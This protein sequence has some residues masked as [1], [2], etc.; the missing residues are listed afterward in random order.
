M[1]QLSFLHNEFAHTGLQMLNHLKGVRKAYV[2][3]YEEKEREQSILMFTD[4]GFQKLSLTELQKLEIIRWREKKFQTEWLLPS[5]WPFEKKVDEQRIGLQRNLL[6]EEERNILVLSSGNLFDHR[7]DLLFIHF[8]QHLNH[9]GLQLSG[10]KLNAEHKQIVQELL[11]GQLLG[12]IEEL[13]QNRAIYSRIVGNRSHIQKQLADAKRELEHR[14]EFFRRHIIQM[15]DQWLD[16]LGHHLPYRFQMSDEALERVFEYKGSIQAL[17]KAIRQAAEVACNTAY[18]ESGL[19]Q[20]GAEDLELSLEEEMENH[21]TPSA[22]THNIR[23]DRYASTEDILDR[24]EQAA[25]KAQEQGEK[26]IGRIVGEYCSPSITNAAITDSIRKHKLR[27]LELFKRYPTRWQV[28]RTEF[29]SITKLEVMNP[30][31]TTKAGLG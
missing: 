28:I 15:V 24:Y 13:R 1:L 26:I 19:L 25:R 9:F 12:H 4:E 7:N 20:I 8:E 17:E 27:I 11:H 18:G 30:E 2:M 6:E 14:D 3:C 21:K 16:Q 23:I 5:E 31:S 29:K 10:K 22:K